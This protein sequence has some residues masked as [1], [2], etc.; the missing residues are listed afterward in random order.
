MEIPGAANKCPYCQ[1]LQRWSVMVMYHPAFAVLLL[2]IPIVTGMILISK[3]FDTGEKYAAYKDQI[4][5]TESQLAFGEAKGGF[6]VDVIGTIKNTSPVSWKEIHF[7][8]DFFDGTG[9]RIDVGEKENYTYV[10]P[11]NETSSFKV[12]FTREFA[13][14]NYSKFTVRIVTAKDAATRW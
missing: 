1:H 2:F 12:S 8:A 7:H 9:K 10:L 13:E 3:T 5:I 11:A 6:T 14:T 4:T